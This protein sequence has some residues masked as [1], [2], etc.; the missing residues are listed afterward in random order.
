[1]KKTIIYILFLSAILWSCED[2]YNAKIDEVENVMVV[3]AQIFYGQSNNIIHLYNSLGFNNSKE[4]YSNVSG[5][6]VWLIDSENTTFELNEQ[7]EGEFLVN[8]R[9]DKKLSYKLRIMRGGNTYES[10]FESVPETPRIDTI[11]GRIETTV[12]NEAGAK[13]VDDFRYVPGVQLYVDIDNNNKQYYRFSAQ[14]IYQYSFFTQ[15]VVMGEIEEVIHFA[16]GTLK[17]GGAFNLA[18]PPDFSTSLQINKHPLYFMEKAAGIGV[19]QFFQGWILI[20][21]QY[22]L[23][24]SAYNFYNDLNNQ[25][26]AEGKLFDPLYVQARN[27]IRCTSNPEQ[28]VLGNFEISTHVE[29]RYYVDY[30]SPE[31]GFIIKP[32][33]YF[34]DIPPFGEQEE[35]PPDFWETANKIYPKN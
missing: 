22:G 9:L 28:V 33:P 24:E 19:G 10:D 21:N 6:R 4:N 13:N 30:I 15:E 23:S 31:K 8:E 3:D 5:A 12:K 20:L 26:Q 27:N 25:L 7:S 14:K 32:I 2:I 29:R 17:P 35:I 11:Y 34:Y 1:M 18:A 16:W